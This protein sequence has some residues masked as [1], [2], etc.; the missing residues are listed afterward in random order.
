MAS[1]PKIEQTL[2][3]YDRAAQQYQSLIASEDT[4]YLSD[5]IAIV[6]KGGRVL[7]LGSGPGHCA[8]AMAQAGLV[9]DASDGS[10]EMV[11]LTAKHQGV[12]AYQALFSELNEVSVYDGIWANFSLLH[13]PRGTLPDCLGRIH[14]ALKAGGLFHIGMKLDQDDGS[15]RLGR[16]YAYYGRDELV[17]MLTDA[18][19]TITREELGSGKGMAGIEEPW[20]VI[21]ARS[22]SE[23]L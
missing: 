9:V 6:P 18:G 20:I 15:D 13:A 23:D 4:P 7:D 21:W 8:N 11:A 16:Y 10:P 14:R 12:R 22:A 2:G 3:Y 17:T 19:F 1:D 5:F